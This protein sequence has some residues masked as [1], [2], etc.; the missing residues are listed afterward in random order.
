VV[1]CP[2]G[3]V[4]RNEDDGRAFKCTFCYDRQKAGLEPACAKACPTESIRFGEIGELRE[5]AQKRLQVLQNRGM[6][7]ASIYNPDTSVG[8]LHAMFIVRGDPRAYNLP[9][10]PEVPTIYLKKGWT[11][12]AVAAGLLLGG[13][14]LAFLSHGDS[15]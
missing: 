1:S 2:F 5:A 15:R 11:S 8:G 7:D 3:V 14:L 10:K 6:R 12:A 4:A 9:P 13:T